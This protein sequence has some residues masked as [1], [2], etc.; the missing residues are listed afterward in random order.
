VDGNEPPSSA[1]E[2][3]ADAKTVVVM[4]VIR[5]AGARPLMMNGFLEAGEGLDDDGGSDPEGYG[6]EVRRFVADA[7]RAL[8]RPDGPIDDVFDL[9]CRVL[10][11]LDET[12]GPQTT[13]DYRWLLTAR[14]AIADRLHRWAMEELESLVG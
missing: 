9:Y 6:P 10:D 3:R 14:Q 1:A 12:P 2:A 8:G 13:G 4:H 11:L 7:V 5:N